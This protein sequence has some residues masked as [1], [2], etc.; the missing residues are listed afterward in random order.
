M[1][2]PYTFTSDEPATF[3]FEGQQVRLDGPNRSFVA[4]DACTAL[5]FINA[6]QAA[7][8]AGLKGDQQTRETYAQ[9]QRECQAIGGG[10]G[11]Q[12]PPP[13]PTTPPAVEN[14]ST[15]GT[16]TL[17]ASGDESATTLN[18]PD[19]APQGQL[20]QTPT[21]PGQSD[22]R[23]LQ[24]QYRDPRNPMADYD[25]QTNLSQQGVP[26]GQLDE[27]VQSV[28]RNDPPNGQ[29]HP[30]FS[31]DN[32]P[33]PFTAVDPINVFS[34]Q[35]SL[36]VT[37]V[38]IASRGFPL[39]LTR[40]YRSGEVYFG[41][42][43]FNWD[44][45]YNVY[46]REMTNGDAAV[47]TGRLTE[48]LYKVAANAGFES[49]LGVFRTLERQAATPL[50]PDRFV[51]TEREGTQMIFERPAGWPRPDRIPLVR[52][53]DRHGNAHQLRYD[54]EARL[55]RVE[56]H[57]GRRLE[58][59]YGDCG[60]LEELRDH[61][62]R[63]WR[64]VHD[65]EIEHL[66][67][68]I[69]P[70]TPEYPDGLAMQYEYDRFRQ[71]PALINNLTRVT[72]PAGRVVVENVYG[73]D[74]NTDDFGRVV[75]QESG[76]FQTTLHATVLQ[77]VPRTPDAINVPA[78]RVEVVDP[79]VLHVYTFN[80]RGDLLDERFRLVED[81]SYRL[82]ARLYRYDAQGNLIER[83]EPDGRGYLYTYDDTNPDPQA[84]GNLLRMTE[85]A[86]PLAP[87]PGRDILRA[88][89][90]PRYQQLKTTRDAHGH[91]T[92]YIYDYEVAAG[93]TGLLVE[94]R[95][96]LVTLP[97]GTNLQSIE[98]FTY[99]AAG[100]LLTHVEVGGTHTFEYEPAGLT[101][102]YIRHRSHTAGAGAVSESFEHDQIGNLTARVDGVGNRT[103]YNVNA[104][105]Q[106]IR[107]DEP[108]GTAWEF[109]Y[110]P[111]GH[112][113]AIIEPRGDYND[114]VLAGA[115]I[116]HDF[117][118]NALGV[119]T[120][121]TQAANTAMPRRFRYRRNAEGIALEALD[122]LDRR[123]VRKVDERGLVLREELYDGSGALA[124]RR[125]N[126]Y[127]R[128]GGLTEA[129]LEGGPTLKLR[130]DGF[131]RLSQLEG[132]DG[133]I[134]AYQRDLRG[135]VNQV[136]IRGPVT[137]GG[138]NVLL[139]RRRW[140]L[141]ERGMV[142]RH[143]EEL[144]TNPAGPFTDVTTT[145]W[146]DAA[147]RPVRIEEPG[148]LVRQREYSATGVLLVERDSLGNQVTWQ[149]DAAGRTIR[150]E[151]V[152]TATSG[153]VATYEWR[154]AYD[155]RG[156]VLIDD[157]PLGNRTRYE[158][159][160]R[161]L[162]RRA[163]NPNG[164]A[165]EFRYDAHGQE[166]EYAT[167][168][169]SVHYDRDA[170][171]RVTRLTDPA[172]VTTAYA[173]DAQD[174]F[175]RVVRADGLDQRYA[176]N[177]AGA[178]LRF[179]DFDG[180]RIDYTY[181][182]VNLPTRIAATPAG[183]A[184]ATPTVDL[185]YDGLRRLVRAAAGPVVHTF[186]FDSLSR[187]L[188]EAGPDTVR[189]TYDQPGRVRTL[190]YPDGRRHR[191]ELD[192]LYR[193][194]SVT[195][196]ID[197]ALGLAGHGLPPGTQLVS[198]EWA[199]HTRLEGAQAAGL[200]C[201]YAYDGAARLS[202]V[203]YDDSG[204]A[205]VGE[206][207]CVRDA[208]G[209]R[210]AERR[211]APAVEDREYRYDALSRLDLAR[212]GLPGGTV[213]L[214]TAGLSQAA[215]DATVAAVAATPHTREIDM[216]YTPGDTPAA[217]VERDGGG[218][219]LVNRAFA[220]NALHQVVTADAMLLG[221]D[222]AGNLT[223]GGPRT[224][225][226]DAFRRLVEVRDGGITV[227]RFTYDGIGRLHTRSDGAGPPPR[228][229]YTG[230]ELIQVS[231]A[232]GPLMQ[233]TPGPGLDQP[234]LVSLASDS[235]ALTYDGIGSLG[236]ACD[237]NGAVLERYAY[238]VFGQPQVLAPDGI[239]PRVASLLGLEPRFQGRPFITSCR[240]YDFRD[241]FYDPR[242]FIYLQPDPYPFADGWSPY[243][244]VG[245]NPLNY[246][247][248]YG[249]W[250]H[251]ALG[252]VI[253]AAV[254]GIGAAL[255]GGDWKDVLVGIGAGAAGGALT[256]ATGNPALG[257]AVAAGLMGAWSGGRVGYQANGAGGALI[258][259]VAGG[260][261]GAG[262]GAA[263]GGVGGRVG[264]AT[265]TAAAGLINRTLTSAGVR[266]TTAWAA[267]RY[268]GMVAGGYAGGATAGV[269]GNTTATVTVDVVTGRPITGAQ[270]WDATYHGL[271]VD[272]PLGAVGA[273]TDRFIMISRFPGRPAN[274]LGAEGETLVG[275]YFG[276]DRANGR[277]RFSMVAS[278]QERRP[279]FPT[280][281][282]VP[283]YG[284]VFEVKNKALLSNDD[285]IQI[286]D[287]RDV[288]TQLGS[289]LWVFSR[290]GVSTANLPPAN[291]M[292]I[293]PIP[294]QPMVIAVPVPFVPQRVPVK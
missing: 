190:T 230:N 240:L 40:L 162:L 17:P 144:F 92:E 70:G 285:V 127:D 46:L 227:T 76:G 231:G 267:G 137:G 242:L 79:G 194:D 260:V 278:G 122:P 28:V 36:T 6:Y 108:D 100:Q 268:G 222:Q 53:E 170:G 63:R 140:D 4:N 41:P 256:A 161:G 292:R 138:A 94:L 153:A 236:A 5:R 21:A 265:A 97:D 32:S 226:Y 233:Y 221:Y 241:R 207:A 23:T 74:P 173:Y 1:P 216:A 107:V 157:D 290:P 220:E 169:A 98:R 104:L 121:E 154:R 12:P 245:Y 273:T 234:P 27:A 272:G 116:R 51:L 248:P 158:Y 185:D 136:E 83:R 166:V 293:M 142:R 281:E 43:G 123:L 134:M 110:D 9:A 81:G 135:I 294:Q 219:V 275:R 172:G 65:D 213:P 103:V 49:P 95:H 44:H 200:V 69:T 288:A 13:T 255:S 20:D 68:V 171:G 120:E 181:S 129:R 192:Q 250:L 2:P 156:R 214:A 42:W 132:A 119:L 174:R 224:Y 168:G 198:Y 101:V 73:D 165:L 78:L 38:E 99:N 225:V 25:V 201:G 287:F 262:I 128:A 235:Y 149:L 141:D 105:G 277:Q 77:L 30:V 34:G 93:G 85:V 115:P 59:G 139:A 18:A 208:L 14:P 283:E 182:P 179:T 82:V 72:D 193:L 80:Y 253:G 37:D 126:I 274:V 237:I 117:V 54:A 35:Y 176:Y 266:T 205:L 133:S 10:P 184:T 19:P 269:L 276:V 196:E 87:A 148:G 197:G 118:Y 62:G 47:W 71:H 52:V 130:Y 243:A 57:A 289:E 155:T 251:I 264:N 64:Y 209:L 223:G 282:T 160:A 180:T 114:A 186:R 7:T 270:L 88:T 291:N 239:T 204:G 8:N 203:R 258:G 211:A 96:P 16:D 249:R 111:T 229:A 109:R 33:Q 163:V 11:G 284:A 254:G 125:V 147:G 246:R 48:E 58:F 215:M 252:A 188:E 66:L 228:L 61:T 164:V 175:T 280:W 206:E 60:L 217:R 29:P 143:I 257:G 183:V 247:D 146:M 145:Y 3:N 210:R 177:P 152:E 15:T 191:L 56:D 259:A 84:R 159:D 89:Y 178:P 112:T 199:G 75:Y 113:A 22:G 286:G 67:A 187:L 189:Y 218:A 150:T 106:V 45:N 279:D 151:V 50:H 202:E 238:D 261:L 167:G 232:A 90:E 124:Y 195:L 212:L 31:Q 263:T 271:A 131:G 39:R 244:F 24:E 102:G 91:L 86:S 26:P 55:E